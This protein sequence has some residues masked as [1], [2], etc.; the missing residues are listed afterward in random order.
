MI[1]R[2]LL[3]AF[4]VVAFQ[5]MAN[6]QCTPS[7]VYADSTF[8]VWPDTVA[9]LPCAFAD[10]VIGYNAVIDLK[11]LTDTVVSVVVLGSPLNITAY[12][13]AFRVN[14][15]TG[16]P[17]G[18]AYIPNQTTWTNGG[19]A[20]NYTA[21][22]GCMSILATQS[23]IQAIISSNPNGV[24]FPLNVIVDAKVNSTD[25]SFADFVLGGK[26]LSEV[27]GVPGVQAIPVSGYVIKVR[28]SSASGCAPLATVELNTTA[29]DVQGNYP[30][31]F[32]GTTE[33]QYTSA[34][35][36]EVSF[37][38]RN[39]VGKQIINRTIKA[40]RGQ[41]SIT[42]NADQLVAGI[43]FYTISDGKKAVTRKMIV[44]AN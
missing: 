4:A 12:I 26:W 41:N 38:V 22:Q 2:Y 42:V 10:E 3:A 7:S 28:P 37:E 5:G 8:G 19:T 18:F 25:N 15:V 24:D 20:P 43:Y 31:P 13:E 33:I 32:S 34:S 40:E 27:S 6:A 17:A 36:R 30:N 16:L 35:R 11:T 39:M 21:V 44:S 1:K 14:S 29:F 23:A 9:N